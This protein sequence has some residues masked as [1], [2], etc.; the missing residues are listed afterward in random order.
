MD[1]RKKNK[2]NLLIVIAVLIFILCT[3][4]LP[5]DDSNISFALARSGYCW[6]SKVNDKALNRKNGISY[7][8]GNGQL[9]CTTYVSWAVHNLYKVIGYP[10]GGVVTIHYNWL[11]N[12]AEHVCTISNPSA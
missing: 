6:G 11:K 4:F 12:N 1:I 8:T 9:V 3:G 10:S 2:K 7:G 5:R